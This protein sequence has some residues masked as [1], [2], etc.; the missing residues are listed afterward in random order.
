[1]SD[2]EERIKIIDT[3]VW[4]TNPDHAIESFRPSKEGRKNIAVIPV[5]VLGELD[6]FKGENYTDRGRNARKISRLI[7]ELKSK[8]G[9]NLH[10]GIPLADNYVLKSDA[11]DVSGKF[12]H[13]DSID[14]SKVDRDI[15][16]L[17]LHYQE[18]GLDTELITQDTNL[19]NIADAFGVEVS[20]WRAERVIQ[21]SDEIDPGWYMIDLTG[22][23]GLKDRFLEKD[24]MILLEDLKGLPISKPHLKAEG[25]FIE[26]P[27]GLNPDKLLPRHY[28]Y[29]LHPEHSDKKSKQERWLVGR[30]DPKEGA[31]IPLDKYAVPDRDPNTNDEYRPRNIQ[32]RLALD[33]LFDQDIKYLTL[34][35]FAGT[36]KTFLAI[37]AAMIQAYERE[38]WQRY[39]HVLIARPIVGVGKSVGYLK[40]DLNKKL[41]PW[42]QPIYDNISVFAGL[43][44]S[45]VDEALEDFHIELGSIEHI[46]GRSLGSDIVIIDEAQNLTGHE[47]RTI[48]TRA[49]DSTKMVFT[50]DPYQIDTPHVNILN[51]GLVYAAQRMRD[52]HYTATI[53]LNVGER[54]ELSRDAAQRL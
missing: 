49:G 5:G 8:H 30:Y 38:K 35:G 32:Q 22:Q 13:V 20:D 50:G 43:D 46:R 18:Q 3:N 54:S 36:G 39:T 52:L 31:V 15:L 47:A 28:I 40:G 25:M 9:G 44:R 37:T 51:C 34:M 21:T 10:K 17:C 29:F 26:I 24:G 7:R 11:T 41:E 23:D 12:G 6:T 19:E 53:G 33:A 42:M 48:L 45:M 4:L 14:V 1:M 27:G 2:L 16:K